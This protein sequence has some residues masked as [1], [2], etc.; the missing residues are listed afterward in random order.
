MYTDDKISGGRIFEFFLLLRDDAASW[1]NWFTFSVL[2]HCN[3]LVYEHQHIQ[4]E[5]WK[6]VDVGIYMDNA[7][8]D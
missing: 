6:Q 8:N 5:C 4:K 3:S 2:R 1:G 7:A